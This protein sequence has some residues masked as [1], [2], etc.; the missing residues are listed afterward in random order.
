[1]NLLSWNCRG[2]GN[3]RAVRVLSELIKTHRPDFLFLSETLSLNSKIEELSSK[4]GFYKW[5]SVDKVDRAGGLAI[6]WRH[7]MKCVV[8]DSSQNHIDVNVSENNGLAWRLT[9]YYGFPERERRRQ[10]WDFIRLLASKS[11]LPWCIM[12]DFNDLL[13][14]KDKKGKHPHPQYLL[15]GFKQAIEDCDLHEIDLSCG[16]Y[17]WEKSKG[18]DN[19]VRERLD[20]AFASNSWWA[21]FPLCTLS[22][23]HA[24]V[25]DHEP[26]KL[27]LFNTSVTK[28]QFRFKFENTWLKEENFHREVSEFWHNLPPT[29]LLPK[30]ISVSSFMARWGR[31]F[32][33]K[34]REKVVKQKEVLDMLNQ[35]EDEVG[36]QMYFTE[37]AKLDDLLFQEETYWK[38]R[39][40]TYWLEEGDT[41]SKFFH[42]AASSRKKMNH[43][44]SLRTDDGQVLHKHG[45]LCSLLKDYYVNI[46]EDAGQVND[47]PVSDNPTRVTAYQNAKLTEKL[48]FAEFTEAIKSMHPDKASGPDGLNPAFFQH[49]WNLFGKEV[50]TCCQSWLEQNKFSAN[51]NDTTL[52]LIPK[53]DKVE[54]AKDLRPIALCNVLYKIVAK[55]LA[56]RLKKILPGLISEEQSAFVPDRNIT[57]NVLVA[58]ELLHYMKRRN[59]GSMGDVAL[60]LDISKAYDRVSWDYLK[61]RMVAMGFTAKWIQWMMLC[62]TSVTYSISFQGS[63]IGPIVPKRGLRQGDPLSPYLFLLCVEGL[64][65]ALKDAA[66]T[67]TISG[68]R[69]CTQAP[70]ITHLLFADDSFLF[71]RADTDETKAIKDILNRYEL[72]SGQAVNY[73]KSAIFFSSN[74]RTD[75]QEEIKNILQVYNN[76]GNSKYLGLPSLVGKSKKSVFNYLKD[77]IWAKIKT[78]STKLLSRA[79]KAVLLRNVAQTIPSYTMSCFLIPKSL[80]QELERMMNAFWWSSSSA[81]NKSIKWLSWSRMSMS[82]KN[83]GLGFRDLHGFNL[84]LLGK[85]CWTLL[86][87]PDAL[88]SRLLKARYYPN[89]SLLQAERKGGA[90]FTWSGIWEAKENMKTGLRWVV[91]DG[92]SINIYNDRWLRG[93]ANFCVERGIND[94]ADREAKVC[95]FFLRDSRQ[96]DENKVRNTFNPGDA[97]AILTVRIPQR[98]T[99]DR[100]TWIHSNNGQ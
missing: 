76:I 58:F 89:C 42:A 90:S 70:S 23:H 25:S 92:W 50:F 43:I 19:W 56:N 26:I 55:V 67:N 69:I 13:C 84:A 59:S 34:F 61:K 52:V 22:V 98:S 15:N 80:C 77:K 38:Q 83:G 40:K 11:P 7:T 74:V 44:S 24:I 78:W 85:Q 2:L 65:I 99:G 62:V 96:W 36:I 75:K 45:D 14:V 5:Y 41:N 97:E 1:M 81:N 9:C 31:V 71:F 21:A 86:K 20:R 30:L 100:L 51:I 95:D 54:E 33:H 82:K 35:R 6:F 64:S 93:R 79:G 3:H 87:T 39:A 57:D 8:L 28:K 88:V 27:N 60:K 17:T 53:K 49:F 47:Y 4:L 63:D 10:A 18:T 66:N 48:S 94:I 91:G 12:G 72:M 37:K 73:Q 29:H 32:F 46:F 16:G 68:C